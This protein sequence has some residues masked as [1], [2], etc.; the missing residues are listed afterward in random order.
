[1]SVL[2]HTPKAKGGFISYEKDYE[3]PACWRT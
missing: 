2:F 1:M 3:P